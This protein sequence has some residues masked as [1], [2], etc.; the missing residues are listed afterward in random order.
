MY[1]RNIDFSPDRVISLYTCCNYYTCVDES[2]VGALLKRLTRVSFDILTDVRVYY[3]WKIKLV[4]FVEWKE[5][6]EE[7]CLPM[8][9]SSPP[10]SA[11]LTSRILIN[12]QCNCS[13]LKLHYMNYMQ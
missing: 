4:L 9:S 6:H 2:V 5:K 3:V 10:R 8:S 13:Q 11:A 12:P 7:L 1:F